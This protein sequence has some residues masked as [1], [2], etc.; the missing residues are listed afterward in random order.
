MGVQDLTVLCEEAMQARLLVCNA[1]AILRIA[2]ETARH[3]LKV[4]A[5][6]FIT[7]NEAQMRSV[8][9]TRAFDALDRELVAEIYEVFFN[10]PG[11]WKRARPEEEAR[12]FPDG[13]DWVRLSNAQLRVACAE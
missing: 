8:Q 11:T 12:Q 4:A 1:A 10:P 3:R 2:N 7:A 9:Q 13:Q 6:G 5:L